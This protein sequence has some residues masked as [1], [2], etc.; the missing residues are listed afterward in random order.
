MEYAYGTTFQQYFI[1]AAFVPSG[2]DEHLHIFKYVSLDNNCRIDIYGNAS[3]KKISKNISGSLRNAM[4]SQH[5][6]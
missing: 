5:Q 3:A 1:L 2:S 4:I 6:M